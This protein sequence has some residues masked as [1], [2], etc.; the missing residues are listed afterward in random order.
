MNWQRIHIGA[1]PNDFARSRRIALYHTNDAGAPD[2]F[3]NLVTSKRPKLFG[4]QSTGAVRFKQNFGVLMDIATPCRDII[5][6][7][8][9]AVLYGHYVVSDVKIFLILPCQRKQ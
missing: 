6:Q 5:M 8:S 4:D 3:N 2:A 7:F 9:K 1:Q